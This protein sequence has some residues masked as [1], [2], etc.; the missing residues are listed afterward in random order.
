MQY[1]YWQ[2]DI[3]WT[4]LKNVLLSLEL[5]EMVERQEVIA[6]V[7][8]NTQREN[9]AKQTLQFEDFALFKKKCRRKISES[10][11]NLTARLLFLL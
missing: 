11:F 4:Q 5:N 1:I 8:M 10:Q 9:Y 3:W 2:L 6:N 7:E